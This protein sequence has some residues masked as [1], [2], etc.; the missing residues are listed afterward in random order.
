MTTVLTQTGLGNVPLE[1]LSIVVLWILL[2]TFGFSMGASRLDALALTFLT[3]TLL[4]QHL[5]AAWTVGSMLGGLTGWVGAVVPT[6]ALVI[7]CYLAFLRLCDAD[8][9]D[10]GGIM[11]AGISAAAV[12]III[13]SLW[14][15]S[16]TAIYPFPGILSS[17]FAPAYT[18]WW[19]VGALAALAIARQRRMWN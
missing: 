1:I 16:F 10:G 11:S 17:V 15:S 13:L 3:A 2:T 4:L 8:F 9:S 14:A 12:V 6:T 5:T 18:F 7:L 19:L